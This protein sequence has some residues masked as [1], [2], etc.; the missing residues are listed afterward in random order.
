MKRSVTW[1]SVASFFLGATF[2]FGLVGG[3]FT[4]GWLRA[5]ARH[6]DRVMIDNANGEAVGAMT[7]GFTV[8]II[9]A[10]VYG[11]LVM[12]AMGADRQ[13]TEKATL[14]MEK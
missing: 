12:R 7:I 10:F 5:A 2:S 3:L 1:L 8:A 6:G 13:N 14:P 9:A 4:A 11:L